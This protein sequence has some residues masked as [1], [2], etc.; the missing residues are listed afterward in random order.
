MPPEQVEQTL[1]ELFH[2]I[3]RETQE[4]Q[5]LGLGLPLARRVI[6][7]HGGTLELNSVVDQG[8]QVV[9]RLPLPN[10]HPAPRQNASRHHTLSEDT[11]Y[12]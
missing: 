1:E 5:G 12:D 4:Q 6:E 3:D 8:T 9:V 11:N 2:Q 7:I 10:D